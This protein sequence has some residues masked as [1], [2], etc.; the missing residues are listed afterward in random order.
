MQALENINLGMYKLV[1]IAP[2]KLEQDNFSKFL[3][4]LKIPLIAI[5][6]AHCVSGWGHDFRPSYRKIAEVIEKLPARPTVAS[7][8][9]TATEYVKGIFRKL[10]EHE[11]DDRLM[12]LY[13][14][15]GGGCMIRNFGEYNSDRVVIN[16]DICAT[17]K[18]YE[19]L[20]EMKL[21]KK[22]GIV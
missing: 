13:I 20:A 2:E 8:T 12:R 6:E 11:Y 15:G 7:F 22:G 5:D 18:G 17:A 16:T 10:H 3:S 19:Y 4:N 14:V 1:Y 9:A 21:R